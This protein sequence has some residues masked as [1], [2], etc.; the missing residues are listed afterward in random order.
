[1]TKYLI[2]L[3]LAACSAT[4]EM[5][6]AGD[7]A[8]LEDAMLMDDAALED[9]AVADTAVDPCATFYWA[10]AALDCSVGVPCI[11]DTGAEHPECMASCSDETDT[12]FCSPDGAFCEGGSLSICVPAE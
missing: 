6:D 7:D 2:L 8:G 11:D 10:Q 9:A 12:I 4:V 3:L 5:P 1:M